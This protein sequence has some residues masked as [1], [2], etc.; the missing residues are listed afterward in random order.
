MPILTIFCNRCGY[1][2]GDD[3]QFCQRCG[4]SLASAQSSVV[5]VAPRIVPPRYAGF[6]IRVIPAVIDFLLMFAASFP[7]KLIFGSVATAIGLSAQMS[8]HEALAMRRVVRIV[9][10]VLV[11]FAYRA[12][13]ESSALQATL[14]KLAVRLKV[15]DLQGNRMTFARASGRYFAKW[16]SALA[17]GL[18]YAMVA[19]DEEKQGLHDRIAGTFV[20]YRD[21][22]VEITK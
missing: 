6:W 12:G 7:L 4:A 20:V 22:D 21:A 15:T 13:M 2:S 19:F 3:A 5:N 16:L 11:V 1:P 8:V 14:G 10:G 18:G 17:L 9:V